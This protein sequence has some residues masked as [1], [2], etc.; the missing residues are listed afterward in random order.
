MAET[1]PSP[2]LLGSLRR[3]LTPLVR[4]MLARGLTLPIAIE[5]LKQV[6]VD[7]ANRDFQLAGKAPTDSRIS[8]LTG[9]HRKDVKRLREMPANDE[10][11]PAKISFGA[12]AVAR[13]T[14][15]PDY[16]DVNGQ[17][18]PLP[19]RSRDKEPSFDS[20][21]TG[22]SRDI[23]PRSLLD[24]W[25]RL[26]V[27]RVNDADEVELVTAAFVPQA[28]DDERLAYYG[29]NLGDHALAA[30]DNVLGTSPAWF[31]RS[32]HHSA[33]SLE[34]V[35]SLRQRAADLGMEL[36]Q[37]LHKQAER[38]NP[39]EKGDVPQRLTCGVYF[40]SAPEPSAIENEQ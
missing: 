18:R 40:Y 2:A 17:P 36:L 12:Q 27:I 24:E 35:A 16:V 5:L 20:L 33:M 29:H 21:V 22:I 3:V 38:Q 10:E 25:Q 32:V 6:F 34:A 13:W 37:D 19:R 28:G 8:L 9:V 15:H 1:T 23:R 14:T 39:P 30:T 11:L 26:G 4:L 7:V 31:E